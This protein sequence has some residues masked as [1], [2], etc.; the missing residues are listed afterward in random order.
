MNRRSLLAALM[1]LGCR[2]S[3]GS[4]ARAATGGEQ[5][6]RADAVIKIL[7]VPIY[8]R[9]GVGSGYAWYKASEPGVARR[10]NLGFAGGSWPER[11]R[12]L[13]RLGCIEEC[14]AER[15]ARMR[16]AHY[17]GFMTASPEENLRQA[18]ESLNASPGEMFISAIQAWMGPGASR[19]RK[20][21][22]KV[23][24]SLGWSRLSV[25]A[26]HV[27]RAF[28]GK[29]ATENV[30]SGPVLPPFLYSVSRAM[31]DGRRQFEAPFSYQGRTYQL[32]GQISEALRMGA[33]FQRKGLAANDRGIL[34][35]DGKIS[36]GSDTK[37]TRFRLWFAA[38]NPSPLP[39]RIEFQ[40]RSFLLLA[41]EADA[42]LP[43]LDLPAILAQGKSAA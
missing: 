26:H 16:E 40:P 34:E 39:L 29:E 3:P 42:S 30:T 28:H 36:D 23:D 20:T 13:N 19:T 8:T 31:R 15:G 41:F 4:T 33:H 7:S 27:R 21:R 24:R 14:V 32:S 35:F 38:S 6:Y 11:A 25:L 18:R 5:R 43:S 10:L 2:P 12:G 22:L 37:T 1:G 17:F 9:T